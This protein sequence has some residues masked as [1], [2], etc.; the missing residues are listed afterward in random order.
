M[1]NNILFKL[2]ICLFVL[3][4]SKGANAQNRTYC[5]G[6]PYHVTTFKD[7]AKLILEKLPWNPNGRLEEDASAI[8]FSQLKTFLLQLND[9]KCNIHLHSWLEPDSSRNILFTQYQ[10]EKVSQ[11]LEYWDSSFYN[12]YI[13]SIIPQ[14]NNHPIF[15]TDFSAE[16]L[17]IADFIGFKETVIKE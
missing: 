2:T 1:R 10:T 16:K 11:F 14:G 6:Y 17:S 15:S 12:N 7:S 4:L 3:L 13:L 8:Y 9:Y 5:F